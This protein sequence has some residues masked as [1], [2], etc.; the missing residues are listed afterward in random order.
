MRTVRGLGATPVSEL[1]P[2]ASAGA[3][4]LIVAGFGILTEHPEFKGMREEFL[5]Y[6]AESICVETKLFPGM[7]ELLAAIES[8]G[9]R[10]GIVT[11]KSTN[12]TK[13]LVAELGLDGRAACVV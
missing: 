12:L 13:K 3:R 5:K 1:R 9:L 11:N 8:K 6:Y 2:Y 10:W 4:G 7:D